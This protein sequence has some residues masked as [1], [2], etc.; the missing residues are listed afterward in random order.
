MKHNLKQ[1]DAGSAT[2]AVKC[3]NRLHKRFWALFNK[4]KSR[5]VAITAIAREFVGF[6]WAVMVPVES[7]ANA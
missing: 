7:T 4:G 5:Q 3:M 1:I 2:I 6:I